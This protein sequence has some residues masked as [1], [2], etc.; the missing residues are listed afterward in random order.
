LSKPGGV[1][2]ATSDPNVDRA[3]TFW[4][5]VNHP[6]TRPCYG[7]RIVPEL[8][9]QLSYLALGSARWLVPAA[10]SQGSIIAAATIVP[11]DDVGLPHIGML[12]FGCPLRRRY[13]KN[14]PAYF[15]YNTIEPS[16]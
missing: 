14:F 11:A 5:R 12:T 3:F 9:G 8:I 1:P 7:E 15:V 6:L 13:A 4:Q 16:S 2:S 10:H